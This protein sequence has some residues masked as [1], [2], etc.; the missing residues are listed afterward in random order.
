[1]TRYDPFAYGQVPLGQKEQ[2]AAAPDDML[3]AAPAPTKAAPPASDWDPPAEPSF[4]PLPTGGNNEEA[5]AFGQ[6]ILGES[7]PVANKPAPGK[8]APAKAAAPEP[9]NPAAR[10]KAVASVPMPAKPPEPVA[11]AKP[12][13]RRGP[14]PVLMPAR[15]TTASVASAVAIVAVGGSVSAWLLVQQQNPVM[16]A[17]LGAISLVGAALAWLMLRR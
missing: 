2:P 1:M 17:I 5:L 15:T 10:P 12:A 8:P 6:D 14:Q 4:S 13:P 16:A 7:A 11:A 3:F 9:S